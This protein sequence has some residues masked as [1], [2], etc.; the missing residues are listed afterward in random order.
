MKKQQFNR[1]ENEHLFQILG[2]ITDPE[3]GDPDEDQADTPASSGT[4]PD[5]STPDRTRT[6]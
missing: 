4:A 1:I 2:G 5:D 6:R 3:L